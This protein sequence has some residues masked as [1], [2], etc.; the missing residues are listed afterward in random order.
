MPRLRRQGRSHSAPRGLALGIVTAFVAWL[1]VLAHL[2]GTLHF[3]LISHEICAD[4]GELVHRAE[5]PSGERHHARGPAALPAG[6]HQ[7]HDH[8]PLVGRRH[9]QVAVA[10]PPTVQIV[11]APV[12]LAPAV[13]EGRTSAP[14]RAA[15]LL[16]A[17]K[18]SPPA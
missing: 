10:A 12:A 9:D 8:C 2:A 13:S 18:Q 17:P 1:S 14:S 11:A 15:L 16:T 7:A 4:H 3:A 6:E 5:A